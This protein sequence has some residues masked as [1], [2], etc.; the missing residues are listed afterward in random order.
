MDGRI[1]PKADSRRR[2][3]AADIIRLLTLTGGRRDVA[4]KLHIEWSSSVSL[5]ITDII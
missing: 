2:A 3:D 4:S 1:K 5:A